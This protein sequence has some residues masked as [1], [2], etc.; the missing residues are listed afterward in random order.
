MFAVS[1]PP[2]SEHQP[3]PLPPEDD[4]DGDTN[5][6]NEMSVKQVFTTMA[7]STPMMHL[8]SVRQQI[9]PLMGDGEQECG[10]HI[11]R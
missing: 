11:I 5:G 7:K 8:S 1:Q 2:W 4:V 10:K 6:A 9:I 3:F